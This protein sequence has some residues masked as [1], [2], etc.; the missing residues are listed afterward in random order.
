[1]DWSSAVVATLREKLQAGCGFDRAW[2]LATKE[3]PP[4]LRDRRRVDPW[5]EAD[6][7]HQD[8]EFEPSVVEFMRT[9][10]EA[11]FLGRLPELAYFSLEAL[12][13]SDDERSGVSH[14]SSFRLAA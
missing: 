13:A 11:A 3:N 10:C 2:Q 6:L 12:A 7:F 8:V 5:Q 4:S 9:H 14:M 1:M